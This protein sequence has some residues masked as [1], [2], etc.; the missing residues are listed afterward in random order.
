MGQLIHEQDENRN[1]CQGTSGHPAFYSLGLRS[2]IAHI[3]PTP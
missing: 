2:R 3:I 1:E